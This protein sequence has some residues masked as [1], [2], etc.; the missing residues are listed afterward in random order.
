MTCDL[1]EKN[2]TVLMPDP[3]SD[4]Q[5]FVRGWMTF[6]DDDGFQHEICVKCAGIIARDF[7]KL[8]MAMPVV[9]IRS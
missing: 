3:T 2:E 1:C 8:K 6:A 7:V 5:L 9:P 4:V